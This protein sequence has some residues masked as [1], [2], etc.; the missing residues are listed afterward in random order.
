MLIST[1]LFDRIAGIS[2][3]GSTNGTVLPAGCRRKPERRSANRLAYGHRTQICRDA[4]RQAGV[5]DTVMLQDISSGGIGC[6]AHEPMTIGETFVLKLLDKNGQAIRIRCKVTRCERGGFGN[7]AYLIGAGFEQVIQHVLHVNDD[8]DPDY[9]D[10]P[11]HTESAPA[12]QAV[13]AA[14]FKS[15]GAAMARAAVGFLRAIDPIRAASQWM[16]KADDFS[17]AE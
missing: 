9:P 7:S 16:H 15:A 12:I 8:G 11:S 1:Q 3:P 13:E 10:V 2:D 4:G 14:S 6:L 17:S 5:W